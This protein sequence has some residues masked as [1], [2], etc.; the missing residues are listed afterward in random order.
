MAGKTEFE[1]HLTDPSW[2]YKRPDTPVL[3]D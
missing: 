1:Q 2:R 3:Q